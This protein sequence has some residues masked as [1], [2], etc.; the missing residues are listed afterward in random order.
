MKFQ[1]KKGPLQQQRSACVVLG[2]WE[3][4]KLPEAAQT[5]DAKAN[6]ALQA[7]LKR[8]DFEGHSGQSIMLYDLP[9]LPQE[10]CLLVGCGKSTEW[11]GDRLIKACKQATTTLKEHGVVDALNTLHTLPTQDKEHDRAWC[12]RQAVIASSQAMYTFDAFKSDPAK[13][14]KLRHMTFWVDQ[15][16]AQSACQEALDEGVAVAE[17]MNY[18]KDLANTPANVCTPE[19]LAKVAKALAKD[20]PKVSCAVLNDSDLK[21]LGMNALLAVGAGS[22]HKPRLITLEYR[23]GK[24][25]QAPVVLVGK[26]ITFDTGGYSLKPGG[27]MIGMKY[28]MS[29]AA[30]V[31]A[32][33]KA[34]VTLGLNQNLI[35]VVPTAENM[36]NEHAARPDDIVTTMSGTT[37]EILNTDAEGRLI[38]CDA[39]TYVERYKPAAVIDVATLTGACI[40]ALGYEATGLMG[41]NDALINALRDASN[42]SLDRAW[43]LPLWDSYAEGLKSPFADLANIGGQAGTITAGCFLKHFTKA[44]PWAHLDV[45]GTAC[46]FDGGKRGST[47]RPVPLLVRYL[48]RLSDAQP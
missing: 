40:V 31:L 7:F 19:H 38:L 36:V 33:F 35:V 17:A 18:M 29:G 20:Q 43:P 16:K 27:S 46:I 47:G 4:K 3:G 8:G 6:G 23:G 26:G 9:N 2:I 44:Y 11:S 1:I 48:K 25:N 42:D 5:L 39:L 41:N 30:S 34:A 24:K 15:A 28:D 22:A 32:A 14:S 10:R 21:S 13:K 45:A 12:V 37:V